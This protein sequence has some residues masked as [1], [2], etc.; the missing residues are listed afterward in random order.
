MSRAA[1]RALATGAGRVMKGSV[2][3]EARRAAGRALRGQ[4]TTAA[5]GLAVDQAQDSW[6]LARGSIDAPEYGRR[7]IANAADAGASLAGAV[8]G[9][10]L[11]SVVPVLGTVAG[12]WVGGWLGGF[13]GRRTVDALLG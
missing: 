13:A 6:S 8:A 3:K 4:W 11:G 10:A 12:A 5:I 1:S 9:A 7:T 2:G